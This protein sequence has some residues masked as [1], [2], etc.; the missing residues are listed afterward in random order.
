MTAYRSY[1]PIFYYLLLTDLHVF[2]KDFFGKVVD[3]A[4]W[5]VISL[6]VASYILPSLGVPA[7]YGVLTLSGLLASAGLM[8]VYP[9]AMS[10][11]ADLTGQKII[12][13]E[14]TLPVPSWLVVVKK[15]IYFALTAAS[16]SMVVLPI[17]KIMLF[18]QLDFS[19][20]SWAK[21][22][23]IFVLT[24]AF[25]GAFALFIGTTVKNIATDHTWMR[26]VFPIWF[27][28]GFQ[29]SWRL[30]YQVSP[31]CAYIDLLN[32]Y[33][34]ITEGTRAALLGQPG[35]LSYWF[36]ITGIVF[37]TLLFTIWGIYRMK[38]KLDFV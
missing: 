14:L 33:I 19:Q 7:D 18:E 37:F 34:H 25:N 5:V 9:N 11:A 6:L 38:K 13:Y 29:F 31:L 27:L 16:V 8:E 35:Y 20:V 1:W 21:L 15:I 4:I 12:S 30:L 32:P 22:V 26:F 28:G 2:K 3:T 17:G 36:C 10:L 24:N 23:L